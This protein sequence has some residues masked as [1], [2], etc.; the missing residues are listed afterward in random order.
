MLNNGI[1]SSNVDINKE[2][3]FRNLSQ[4]QADH[5]LTNYVFYD[6][7]MYNSVIQTDSY[8]EAS[9]LSSWYRKLKLIPGK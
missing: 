1:I 2:L 5:R 4:Q 8:W 6:T 3:D 9:N 7:T